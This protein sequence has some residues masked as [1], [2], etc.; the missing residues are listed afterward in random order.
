MLELDIGVKKYLKY[1]KLK[2]KKSLKNIEIYTA[3]K[4][5]SQAMNLAATTYGS[6]PGW[7]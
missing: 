1:Q 4:L 3:F 7:E 2:G 5:S 6:R